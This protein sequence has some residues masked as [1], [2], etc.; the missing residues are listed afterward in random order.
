M[1]RIAKFLKDT[2]TVTNP[3]RLPATSFEMTLHDALRICAGRVQNHERSGSALVP[4]MR[5]RTSSKSSG[6]SRQVVGGEADPES[7]ERHV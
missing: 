3:K 2:L 7:F 5:T 4:Q 6:K 1:R